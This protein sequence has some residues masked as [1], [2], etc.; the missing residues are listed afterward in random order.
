MVKHNLNN[1]IIDRVLRGIF[2]DKNDNIMFSLNQIQ[3]FSLNSTSESQEITDALGV[4]IMELMRSKSIE[5]SATNA[6]FDLGLMASQYGTEKVEATATAKL[7][8]PRMEKFEVAAA[9]EGKYTLKF[10]PVK[11]PTAIYALN[12]DSTLGAKY[13]SATAASETAFAYDAGVITVPTGLAADTELFVMYEYE[14]ENAVEVVNKADKFA[15]MGRL[16]LEALCYDVCDPETKMFC[17]VVMP[18]FQ[19]SNDFDWSLGGDDQT[20]AFSG[21]AHVDYCD[22]DKQMVRVVIVDDEEDEE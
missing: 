22:K 8:V 21:K 16:T 1:I 19:L 6:I 20:H 18:R 7:P 13:V 2:S 11:A 14:S 12:G 4:T 17:Y 3:D 5:A 15:N 10:T 9:K